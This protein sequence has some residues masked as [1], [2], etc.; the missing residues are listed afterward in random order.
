MSQVNALEDV[1]PVILAGGEGMRLRPAVQSWLGHRKPKQYC[2]FIGTRSMLQHTLDRADQIANPLH[3]VTIVG[4]AHWKEALS[5]LRGRP[6]GRLVC[7][8]CNRDT[9]AAIYLALSQVRARAPEATVVIFPSDHFVFPEER[10]LRFVRIAIEAAKRLKVWPVLLGV[11]P[12]RLEADYGWVR[13]GALIGQFAGQAVRMIDSFLEKPS[14]DDCKALM[15]DR[16]L[17][18]TLVLA[19]RADVLWDLGWQFLPDLMVPFS[20]YSRAVGTA[21]EEKL[22]QEIY[23]DLPCRS[24]STGV[25]ER[26]SGRGAIIELTGVLWCDWGKAERITHTLQ[27]LGRPVRFTIPPVVASPQ[28]S[29]AGQA[30][31]QSRP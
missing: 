29:E 17:W 22:L 28:V 23:A 27:R 12:N 16:G 14:L 3:R 21:Q 13:P 26:L 18:N 1:W 15:S 4:Q 10:F 30:L 6:A 2:A 20:R 11:A 25:L 31:S 5:Q 19:S 24:F 9:A 8:P 7:Q